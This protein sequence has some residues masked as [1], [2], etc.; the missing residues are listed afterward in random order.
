MFPN[1]VCWKGLEAKTCCCCCCCQVASVMTD[2]MWPLDGSPPGSPV[3]GVLQARILE[4]VKD[5]L[6]TLN[7]T[8]PRAWSPTTFSRKKTQDFLEKRLTAALRQGKY[9]MNLK[10][11]VLPESKEML[12]KGGGGRVNSLAVQWAGLCTFAGRGLGSISWWRTKIPQ[13]AQHSQKKGC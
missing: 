13:D 9:N 12:L 7:T 4:W 5:M 1:V 2:S 10:H 3:P 11:L 8:R 6:L